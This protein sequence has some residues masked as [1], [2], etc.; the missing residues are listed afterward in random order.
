VPSRLDEDPA[1]PPPIGRIRPRPSAARVTCRRDPHHDALLWAFEGKVV[2]RHLSSAIDRANSLG[3]AKLIVWNV[4]DG[5]L[6]ALSLRELEALVTRVLGAPGAPR[7][8]A[9]LGAPGASLAAAA[10]LVAAAEERGLGD[11][12]EAFVDREAAF[13][14]LG[15]RELPTTPAAPDS[16]LLRR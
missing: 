6:S 10:V 15:F 13:E 8:W 4:V 16:E 7:K 5:D 1:A 2:Y 14:W 12:V 11:R 3:F 9:I